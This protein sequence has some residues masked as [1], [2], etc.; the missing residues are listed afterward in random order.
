[1]YCAFVGRALLQGSVHWN[2]IGCTVELCRRMVSCFLSAGPT[3]ELGAS[4]GGPGNEDPPSVPLASSS[5]I[6][7]VSQQ[8]LPLMCCFFPLFIQD[9]THAFQAGSD[10]TVCFHSLH[11]SHRKKYDLQDICLAARMHCC[12]LQFTTDLMFKGIS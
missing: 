11:D 6:A 5:F 1:M 12:V 10:S 3:F 9:H 2:E 7:F 8:M 4:Q